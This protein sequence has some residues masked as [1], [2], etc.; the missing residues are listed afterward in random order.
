M[1]MAAE[2]PKRRTR[3][4]VRIK[5][6]KKLNVNLDKEKKNKNVKYYVIYRVEGKQR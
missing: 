2:C 6:C 3:Q 1:A 5:Q 4:S